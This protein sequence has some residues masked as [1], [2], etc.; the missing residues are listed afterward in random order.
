MQAVGALGD[1][2]NRAWRGGSTIAI[3]N[4]GIVSAKLPSRID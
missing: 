3:D 2:T 4:G 1:A